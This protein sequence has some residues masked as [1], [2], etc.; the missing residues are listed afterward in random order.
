MMNNWSLNNVN[1]LRIPS[2]YSNTR[3]HEL[4]LDI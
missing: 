2:N 1:N 4:L 3:W